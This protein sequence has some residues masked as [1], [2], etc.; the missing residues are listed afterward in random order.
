MDDHIG[1]AIASTAEGSMGSSSIGLSTLRDRLANGGGA[2]LAGSPFPVLCLIIKECVPGFRDN[3]HDREQPEVVI[4]KNTP[5]DL[6]SFYESLQD[7]VLAMF[8]GPVKGPW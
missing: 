3:L 4:S 7:Y 8:K 6:G 1:A 2:N 5:C